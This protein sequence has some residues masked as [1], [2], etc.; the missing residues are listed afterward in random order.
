MSGR[1]AR[2]FVGSG[3]GCVV[4][5]EDLLAAVAELDEGLVGHRTRVY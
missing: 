1:L 4:A 2:V 3:H 5:F